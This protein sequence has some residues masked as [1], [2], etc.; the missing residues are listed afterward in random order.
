M[1]K[2][3][4]VPRNELIASAFFRAG[5][6]E[7]W[8]RGIEK[9]CRDFKEYGNSI[10]KYDVHPG[11]IM[12]CVEATAT[13]SIP[14]DKLQ[15]SH[16]ILPVEGENLPVTLPV[17]DDTLPVAPPVT[18]PVAQSFL[19]RLLMVLDHEMGMTELLKNLNMKNRQD[20]RERYI[21]PAMKF[22]Y[23]EYTIPERPTSRLQQYRLTDLGLQLRIEL[24]KSGNT[25]GN[26]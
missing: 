20:V 16:A 2:H 13:S 24:K 25:Q 10:P 12:V 26:G 3:T 6:V 17:K 5:F 23:I 21:T 11:D 14:G 19:G 15:S 22:G 8:G 9:A 18:L 4:S 7:R 1:G